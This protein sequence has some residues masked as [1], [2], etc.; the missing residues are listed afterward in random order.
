MRQSGQKLSRNVG[1]VSQKCRVKW[2]KKNKN[3]GNSG[4]KGHPKNWASPSRTWRNDADGRR[5][6]RLNRAASS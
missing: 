6:H 2:G 5:K 3:V 4:A 1:K